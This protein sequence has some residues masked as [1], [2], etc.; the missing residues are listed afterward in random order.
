ML[1][2]LLPI[3]TILC[4]PIHVLPYKLPRLTDWN[5]PILKDLYYS[6][7]L[8]PTLIP[9]FHLYTTPSQMTTLILLPKC[10][11]IYTT[12]YATPYVTPIYN[13]LDT[14]RLYFRDYTKLTYISWSAGTRNLHTR[15]YHFSL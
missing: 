6:T 3:C 2:T 11:K 14:T 8:P 9:I 10:Y 7:T 13:S 12:P 4:Y 15:P 5:C 1:T